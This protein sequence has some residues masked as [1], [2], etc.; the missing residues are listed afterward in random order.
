MEAEDGDVT[1]AIGALVRTGSDEVCETYSIPE[2][3]RRLG[4]STWLAY[5]AA[6]AGEIPTLRIAGRVLVPRAALEALLAG[7]S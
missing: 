6:R 5:R 2:A 3:A 4:I 7:Q 1:T